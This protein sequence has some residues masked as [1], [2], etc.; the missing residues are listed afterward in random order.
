MLLAHCGCRPGVAAARERSPRRRAM[1]DTLLV[2]PQ[3]DTCC[4]GLGPRAALQH[5]G[6]AEMCEADKKQW[7]EDAR[8][9][10]ILGACPRSLPSVRSGILC[11]MGFIGMC[12]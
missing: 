9:A 3:Q 8:V 10:A 6:L 12:V 5:A 2:A 1:V 11:Y 7:L 4:V